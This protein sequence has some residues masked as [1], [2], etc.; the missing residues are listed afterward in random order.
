MVK[1]ISVLESREVESMYQS[2]GRPF[3]SDDPKYQIGAASIHAT[4]SPI[5]PM[6]RGLEWPNKG[7]S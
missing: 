5:C 6:N 1:H 3:P 2:N 4:N 7:L